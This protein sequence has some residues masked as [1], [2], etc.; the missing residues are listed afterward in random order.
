VAD[1]SR[2]TIT[3]YYSCNQCG[4]RRV[5]CDVPA[6]GQEDVVV[7]LRSIVGWEIKVDHLRRS[8]TCKATE[9]QDLMVPMV[10]RKR[11]G[12]PTAQ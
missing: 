2:T 5:P 11:V 1:L 6:R 12:D 9:V 3:V 4:L 8:P 7:W 10:G